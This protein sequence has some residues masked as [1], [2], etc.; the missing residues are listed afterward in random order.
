MDDYID[1]ILAMDYYC[2]REIEKYPL[3]KLNSPFL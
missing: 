2:H 1:Y 3:L